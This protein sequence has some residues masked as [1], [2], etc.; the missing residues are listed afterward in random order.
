MTSEEIKSL[1]DELPHYLVEIGQYPLAVSLAK[2]LAERQATMEII[3]ECLDVVDDC[4][5][6]TGHFRVAKNSEQRKKIEECLT[7][8]A[9]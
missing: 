8:A 3:R 2:L 7:K 4:Y 5:D 9:Q 1:R 6:A